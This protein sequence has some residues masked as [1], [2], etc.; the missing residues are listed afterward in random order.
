MIS[1]EKRHQRCNFGAETFTDAVRLQLPPE[2]PFF[3]YA[4][5]ML[6]FTNHVSQKTD[7]THSKDQGIP[8]QWTEVH[9]KRVP[10]RRT[11]DAGTVGTELGTGTEDRRMVCTRQ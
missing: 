9:G 3:D 4:E 1:T 6:H 10:C 5:V 7:Y 11:A 2:M 8:L